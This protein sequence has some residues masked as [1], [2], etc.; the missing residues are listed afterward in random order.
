VQA[1]DPTLYSEAQKEALA[2]TSP[3]YAHWAR[4]LTRKRPYLAVIDG[5][6]VGFMELEPDGHMDCTYVDPVYQRCGVASA[7][8]KHTEAVAQANGI[9]RL[10][11]EAAKTASKFFASLGFKFIHENRIVRN[12]QIL[13]NDA[14]EK[15]L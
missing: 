3:E 8:Y 11:V 1:I 9:A 13:I 15:H 4:R 10:Y 5:R 2:P 6:I 14:M 12:G 7:L